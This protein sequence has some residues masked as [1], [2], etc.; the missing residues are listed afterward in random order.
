MKKI[1]LTV[2]CLWMIG[3]CA[4]SKDGISVARRPPDA[5]KVAQVRDQLQQNADISASTTSGVDE[6]S[7]NKRQLGILVIG[8]TGPLRSME[9]KDR[10]GFYAAYLKAAE[11][12]HPGLPAALSETQFQQKLV[13]WASVQISGIPGIVST[14]MRVLVPANLAHDTRFA[15][16]AGS[17]LVGTT[18]DLVAAKGD[19]DGLL[20]LDRVLCQDDS[21]YHA[22]ARD[23]E[24]GIFDENTGQELDR[25]RKPKANGRAVNIA[26]YRKT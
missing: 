16:A 13:G 24:K 18:G 11:R 20:W 26:S 5:N 17:F 23:Y 14:R 10:D 6:P 25:D 3:G 9:D 21:T 1:L 22:C 4:V 8:T 19:V 7:A 12:W 2:G 15:S